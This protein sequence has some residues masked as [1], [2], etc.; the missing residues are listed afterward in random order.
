MAVWREFTVKKQ[1]HPLSP[2]PSNSP[3]LNPIESLFAWMKRF[4]ENDG[5]TNEATLKEAVIKA[6]DSIPEEHLA[7]MDSIP[8]RLELTLKAKGARINY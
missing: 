6:Y 8:M 4:V 2:W 1:L 3:D 5:P 7:L